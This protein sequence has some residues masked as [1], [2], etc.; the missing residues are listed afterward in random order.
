MPSTTEDLLRILG[1]EVVPQ[2]IDVLSEVFGLHVQAYR[3]ADSPD[4]VYGVY[5]TN[6]YEDTPYF[7]GYVLTSGLN[8]R[9]MAGSGTHD[10]IERDEVFIY[11]TQRMNTGDRVVF[12]LPSGREMTYVVSEI[13]EDWSSYRNVFR[14]VLRPEHQGG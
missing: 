4:D 3:Y 11:T 13:D 5:S 12:L 6:T 14:I 2:V 9:A 10:S 8:V 7:D 1:E